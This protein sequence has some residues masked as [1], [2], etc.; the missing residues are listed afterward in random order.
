MF[1]RGS[2]SRPRVEG[3]R[4]VV[5]ALRIEG[6]ASCT[7]DEAVL[8]HGI[9][10]LAGYPTTLVGRQNGDAHEV[11]RRMAVV[12]VRNRIGDGHVV[13]HP[14]QAEAVA[15]GELAHVVAGFLPFG[16][17]RL[18]VDALDVCVLGQPQR[19]QCGRRGM[20]ERLV[21]IRLERDD[22]VVGDK[23]HPAQNITQPAI[24]PITAIPQCCARGM[25][26]ERRCQQANQLGVVR[27]RNAVECAGP[28][29]RRLIGCRRGQQNGHWAFTMP[30]NTDVVLIEGQRQ[31]AEPKLDEA[32]TRAPHEFDERTVL[33][34]VCVANRQLI[35]V[36]AK[37]QS[38]RTGV[39]RRRRSWERKKKYNSSAVIV[40]TPAKTNHGAAGCWIAWPQP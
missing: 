34:D 33:C 31:C 5:V 8:E 22:G 4:R 3:Q 24:V 30:C 14:D 39:T 21:V 28:H 26:D 9:E 17:E 6:D 19:C 23:P 20:G 36:R 40:P 12:P 7:L 29:P 10:Q 38:V 15:A 2:E 11:K 27:N 1:T 37:H 16:I 13:D 25:V 35:N 18:G 32:K